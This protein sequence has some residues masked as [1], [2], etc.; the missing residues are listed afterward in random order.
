MGLFRLS[1]TTRPERTFAPFKADFGTARL[2]RNPTTNPL[3]GLFRPFPGPLDQ[4]QS[5]I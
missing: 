4:A 2:T 1:L 3:L 5:S